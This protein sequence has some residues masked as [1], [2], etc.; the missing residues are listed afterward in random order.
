MIFHNLNG[1]NGTIIA[2]RGIRRSFGGD[3]A[4]GDQEPTQM[5]HH[6]HGHPYNHSE[7]EQVKSNPGQKHQH[8][9]NRK[10][11]KDLFTVHLS[12]ETFD[13][14]ACDH[15]PAI[16]Q[17]EENEF[18]RQRDENRRQHHHTHRHQHR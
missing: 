15:I 18:K 2:W 1:G 7:D 5:H 17:H 11:L 14:A 6:G 12:P 8:N 10:Q 9:T 3:D 4:F 13:Q 16:D